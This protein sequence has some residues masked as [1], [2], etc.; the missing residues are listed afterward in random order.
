[1]PRNLWKWL[2]P[3]LAVSLLAPASS[4]AACCYFSAKNSDILQPAQKVFLTWDPVEKIETFT[5]QPKFEGNALDFGMVIPTPT[6]PKLHEM[7]RDTFK[8]LAIYS[9][10]KKREFPHSKL[11]PVPQFGFGGGFAGGFGGAMPM[12][13]AAPGG[14]G[15]GGAPKP[16]PVRVLEAGVIGSLDYKIIEAD[17]ADA[18]FTWLKDHKYSYAGDE[19]TLNHYVQKKWIFTVMKIDTMQMK[20]NK[21]GTF[22]GEVTPTRFQFASEKLVYPLKITQ[23]SVK[24]KT[25]ALFYVQAPTKVDL[26]GDFSY[27]YTW[28]P[29]LQAAS[30]CTPG[31]LPSK[32][33]AWIKDFAGQTPA[34]LRRA[35]ELNFRFQAGQRPQPNQKGHIPTTMEWARKLT[36]TDLKVLTGDAPY[37]ETVPNPDEG[38]TQADVNDALRRE[39]VFKVIRARLQ[40]AQQER[41]FGYMVRHLPAEDLRGLRQLTGHLQANLFITKFRKTFA[42]DEMNDDLVIVPARYNDAEDQSEY[43]EL[44]PVSPP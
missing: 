26:Q 8:H 44:L 15:G 5:V 28:I 31:G 40:K 30:G 34:L 13:G 18:L 11:L 33:E 32:S 9:I 6:Q 10:M 29:M 4:Q 27:Q 20:R 22:A 35:Q 42:R 36:A 17:R 14:L 1:M 7:P 19:A 39:A 43:E 41:P 3:S 21:D 23:I 24:D 2:L 37:S 12:A 16:P 38:F 25:E